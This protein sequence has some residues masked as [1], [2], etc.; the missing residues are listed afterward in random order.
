[1]QHKR[2]RPVVAEGRLALASVANA[3][4]KMRPGPPGNVVKDLGN[5]KPP[6]R[7]ARQNHSLERIQ[8]RGEDAANSGAEQDDMQGETLSFWS[9]A[10]VMQESQR[11]TFRTPPVVI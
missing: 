9:K 7:A 2:E 4:G 10:G 8:K 1:E 11:P 3:S 5:P 6:Y